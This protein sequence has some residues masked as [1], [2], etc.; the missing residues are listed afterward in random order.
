[1]LS[2]AR[3]N[4]NSLQERYTT[5]TEEMAAV[6]ASLEEDLARVQHALAVREGR[7]AE[8]ETEVQSKE[9]EI[10]TL[11]KEL[12]GLHKTVEV[13][14]K[15]KLDIKEEREKIVNQLQGM[16]AW[17]KEKELRWSAEKQELENITAKLRSEVESMVQALR[18]A[19]REHEHKQAMWEEE[20]ESWLIQVAL[21]EE[22][23]AGLTEEVETTAGKSRDLEGEVER[24]GGAVKEGQS[25]VHALQV[26]LRTGGV[27]VCVCACACTIAVLFCRQLSVKLVLS[28]RKRERRESGGRQSSQPV[29]RP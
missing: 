10:E 20:K 9:N 8:R 29:W 27:C 22:Q 16:S 26:C 14:E 23:V 21:L 6:K 1:M 25:T 12:Q 4:L 19:G 5:E 28:V 3:Q 7:L 15:E 24:L 13:L 11:N 18:S 17:M 2:D